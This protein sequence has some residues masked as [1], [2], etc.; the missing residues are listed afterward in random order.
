MKEVHRKNI[1]QTDTK[2]IYLSDG[3]FSLALVKNSPIET[4]GFQ[5]LGFHVQSIAEIQ[6]RLKKSPPFLYPPEPKVEILR[7][8][9][10]SPFTE[11][12]LRDPDGNIVDLSEKGWE[13]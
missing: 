1:P 3:N 13:V 7:R 6:E 8:T 11:Y 4:K 5:V 2:A 12:Y 10:E 9:S